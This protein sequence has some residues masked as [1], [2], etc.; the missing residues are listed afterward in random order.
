MDDFCWPELNPLGK[1]WRVYSDSTTWS[2]D[3]YTKVNNVSQFNSF[4]LD[5]YNM[6]I[7]KKFFDKLFFNVFNLQIM[8]HYSRQKI[9]L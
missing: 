3:Q 6:C 5:M 1:T 8:K 9:L 7:Y 2:N 4:K